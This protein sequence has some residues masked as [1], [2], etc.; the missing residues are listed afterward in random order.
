MTN[1]HDLYFP[2]FLYLQLNSFFFPLVAKVPWK[3]VKGSQVIIDLT[4]FPLTLI[5]HWQVI[6]CPVFSME[7]AN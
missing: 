4:T 5:T 2:A 7:I 3:A 1:F 6:N